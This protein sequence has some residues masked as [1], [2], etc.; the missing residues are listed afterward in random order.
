MLV[1][2]LA[3]AAGAQVQVTSLGSTAT[4]SSTSATTPVSRLLRGQ[5]INALDGGAVPRVLVQIN[6]RSVLTDY[7]GRFSF[8]DFT[9]TQ[10]FVTLTK[11]NFSQSNSSSLGN[12]RQ[13]IANLDASIDLKI[14]PNAT[15][16]GTVTGRDGLPLSHVLVS[17]KHGVFDQNG[18]RWVPVHSIQT[19]LHGEY[20]FRQPS[21]RYQVAIGYVARSNDIGEAILPIQFPP[22]SSSNTL[23][24]FEVENGQEKHIDLRPR[25]GIVYPVQVKLDSQDAQRGAQFYAVTS[26]GEAFQVPAQGGTQI[27]LPTGTYTL[28]ARLENRDSSLEGSTRVTVTARQTDPAVIHLEPSAVVPVELAIDPASTTSTNSANSIPSGLQAQAIQQPD[29]RQFNLRLHNLDSSGLPMAQDIALRQNEEHGYEFRVPPGRYRLQAGGGGSWWIE[30]ATSGVTNLMSSDITISSGGSGMPIRIV[31]NNIQGMVSA[32][33]KFADD[34]AA[35]YVYVIPANPSLAQINPLVV[36]NPGQATATVSTRLP[37]GSYVAVALDH[38]VEEDLRD[39][40][41]LS[42]FSTGTRPV[43]ISAS[44]TANVELDIAQEKKQ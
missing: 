31:A 26:G 41:V 23:D 29:P 35:A 14:Y 13:K 36:A 12:A 38:R 16:T 34:T 30:S 11:P 32:T 1:P 8:P 37:A 19:D 22:N 39:P 9:D 2:A 24:Y 21:G 28:H 43:E 6:S 42:H 27:T 15:I 40:E 17:L 44:G 10:A 33:V 4:S 25:T 18:W 5:V 20:R 3:S 7:Q